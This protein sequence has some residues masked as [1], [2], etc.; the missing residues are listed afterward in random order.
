MADPLI[1]PSLARDANAAQLHPPHG[2]PSNDIFSAFDPADPATYHLAAVAALEQ[3]HAPSDDQGST[4]AADGTDLKDGRRES[5]T[6]R[7]GPLIRKRSGWNSFYKEQFAIYHA[8]NPP[9][10]KQ[11]ARER[12]GFSAYAAALWKQLTP[13]QKEAYVQRASEDDALAVGRP[14]EKLRRKRTGLL[15]TLGRIV[16]ELETEFG[17]ESLV[18]WSE[19]DIPTI[20]AD[21]SMPSVNEGEAFGIVGSTVGVRYIEVLASAQLGPHQFTSFIQHNQPAEPTENQGNLI[22]GA[23]KRKSLDIGDTSLGLDDV[24]TAGMRKKSKSNI[25]RDYHDAEFRRL[26]LGLLNAELPA[27]AQKTRLPRGFFGPYLEKHGMELVG[28][29]EKP[30]EIGEGGKIGGWSADALRKNLEAVRSGRVFLRKIEGAEN[31][32][33]TATAGDEAD[34]SM[35]EPEAKAE[36]PAQGNAGAEE[37]AVRILAEGAGTRRARRSV[38]H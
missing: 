8:S 6:K 19:K 9:A 10:T 15:D 29:P 5:K 37:E 26:L 13:G 22:I 16:A 30:V 23:R 33:A 25:S 17:V 32:L 28:L 35:E 31:T 27:Q 36:A 11:N 24:D 18:F 38:K 20:Q 14:I 34:V 7:I 12:K 21:G 3:Q 4:P 2:V 1:D